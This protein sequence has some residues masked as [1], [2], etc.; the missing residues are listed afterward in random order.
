[1]DVKKLDASI[2]KN[3]GLIKK[4]RMITAENKDSIIKG[5]KEINLSKFVSEGV[6]AVG[7][8]NMKGKDIPAAVQ[9]VSLLHLRY[10]NF[11]SG[12]CQISLICKPDVGMCV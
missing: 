6:D 12:M 3:E 1:M 4:L 10:A 11:A 9:I 2:K 8:A 7:E 5:V